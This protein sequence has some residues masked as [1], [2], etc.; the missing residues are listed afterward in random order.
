ML[1]L[2]TGA[3]TPMLQTKTALVENPLAEDI[4]LLIPQM[5]ATM[6]KEQGVGL[7]A[8]QIGRSIRMAVA[9]ADG[10]IYTLINPEIT[11]LSEEKILF[12]EGCLSL[13]GQYFSIVRSETLTLKYQDER[14]LP[15]KMRVTGFLAVVIQHEVDHLD[16]IL[17]CD[18]YNK[19]QKNPKYKK[20]YGTLD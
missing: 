9:E 13:P 8:P 18:R 5:I 16:G 19:Q 2:V 12:E 6:H 15:K 10:K 20:L 11:T 17:I 4:Q 14:G 3:G 1:K 7:A